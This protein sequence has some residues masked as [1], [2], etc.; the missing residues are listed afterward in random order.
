[1]SRTSWLNAA[2]R[3]ATRP[4]A[5]GAPSSDRCFALQLRR[6]RAR[7]GDKWRLDEVAI[8]ICGHRHWL[9]RAVDQHGVVLDILVQSRRDQ[10]AAERFLRQ[11]IDGVGYEPRVVITDKL[12]SYPPAIRR[13][14]PN[15][16]HRRHKGLNNRAENSHLPVRKRERVMQ[17]FKSTEHVQTFL[18]VFDPIG[19]HFRPRRHRLSASQY[20]LIRTERFATWRQAVGLHIRSTDLEPLGRARTSP[21]LP[22]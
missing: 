19:N 11:V 3:S 4:Y 5:A 14:L 10:N 22:S 8:R 15:V 16:D 2:F 18:S 12:A 21:S 13:V 6:R 17:R 7:P 20:R 9:W 1:M